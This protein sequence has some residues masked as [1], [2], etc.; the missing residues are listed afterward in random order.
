[1]KAAHEL[2]NSVLARCA[3]AAAAPADNT[4]QVGEIIDM[5]GYEACEFVIVT[6]TLADADATFTV[7]MEEGDQSDLSDAA[8]VADLDMLGTEADAGFTFADDK[9]TR[10]IGYRGNKR[11]VR[12]TIT[13]A[14][15]ASA[16]PMAAAALMYPGTLYPPAA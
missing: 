13:P 2:H 8:T 7:L 12:L 10:M 14:G 3:V 15:N 1:M 6:G 9:A 16:A 11:Y 5:Q 4:A